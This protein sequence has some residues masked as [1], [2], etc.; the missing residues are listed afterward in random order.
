MFVT[1]GYLTPDTDHLSDYQDP[2]NWNTYSRPL[3]GDSEVLA[4]TLNLTVTMATT[5]AISSNP[6]EGN[7]FDTVS[8]DDPMFT[9]HEAVV[10]S[11]NSERATLSD[12]EDDDEASWTLHS[13][14]YYNGSYKLLK[15]K[16]L[17]LELDEYRSN[18][19]LVGSYDIL[20]N[21]EHA[22]LESRISE[23]RCRQNTD[24]LRSFEVKYYRRTTEIIVNKE[25]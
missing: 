8:S 15:M 13:P 22:D 11:D 23:V 2:P 12:Q 9:T 20:D 5:T 16:S 19:G 3:R 25:L 21:T 4:D 10:I 7:N 1:S 14:T 24:I 17:R 6:Q 18:K